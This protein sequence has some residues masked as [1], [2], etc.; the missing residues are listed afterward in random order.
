MARSAV[1]IGA[2]VAGVRTAQAL[3]ASGYPDAITLVD[4]DPLVPYDRPPLSK[5]FLAGA[6]TTDDFSL[7]PAGQADRLGVEILRGR[8][9]VSLDPG[10]RV[11]ELSGGA[12]LAYDV[13]VVATGARARPSP[14]P[15]PDRVFV[16]RTLS[17]AR[18]L[19]SAL[20]PGRRLIV[21]GG[22]FIGAEVATTARD[23]GLSVTVVDPL[24]APL[25]RLV[26]DKVGRYLARL[27]GRYGVETRFGVAAEA[28]VADGAGLSARLSDGEVI[29]ADLA[30]VG[31]GTV[32]NDDWLSRSG[33]VVDD[34]VVCDERG[35]A[36]GTGS[37]YAVGDVARWYSPGHGCHRRIEHWTSA[38]D[39]AACVGQQI[40][41]PAG[42]PPLPGADYVWS[43]QYGVTVQL[44]GSTHATLEH[45]WVR[46]QLRPGRL[47]ILYSKGGLLRGGVTVDWPRAILA[48]RRALARRAPVAEVSRTLAGMLGSPSGAAQPRTAAAAGGRGNHRARSD[49]GKDASETET[50]SRSLRAKPDVVPEP[51][52]GR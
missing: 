10:R 25:A 13:L 3:R 45:H 36:D 12:A 35:R 40:A 34:G 51:G 19:R 18:A 28:V 1:I 16:L 42:T 11:V 31:I 44:A 27:P 37:V 4:Q 17:D 22:G 15:V 9:A 23:R 21:I 20:R 46:D 49:A 41:Q 30:V 43:D 2:S 5:Q 24:V 33:L 26:G 29:R 7:L 52:K 14:W 39:Q 6:W 32:P 38:V 47:A 48:C 8:R 50:A